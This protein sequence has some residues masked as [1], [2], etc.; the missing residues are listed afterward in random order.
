MRQQ[1]SPPYI[2]L[3]VYIHTRIY[4]ITATRL[5][6][7]L[8]KK[9]LY[10]SSEN[11]INL[12][13]IN[14][15]SFFRSKHMFIYSQVISNNILDGDLAYRYG[16]VDTDNCD[17]RSSTTLQSTLRTCVRQVHLSLFCTIFFKELFVS[18]VNYI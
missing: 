3:Y 6:F 11:A 9:Y 12:N 14:K 2:N 4:T 18:L 17:L 8:R 5:T 15:K 7:L 1:G 10:V 13:L 16:F